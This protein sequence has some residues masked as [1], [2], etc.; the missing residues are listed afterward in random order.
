MTIETDGPT[1]IDTSICIHIDDIAPQ[2]FALLGGPEAP[3]RPLRAY[4]DGAIRS[5]YLT[6]K[7]GWRAGGGTAEATVQ[8]FVRAGQM[9]AD[10]QALA[11]LYAGLEE[12]ARVIDSAAGGLGGCP[13]APGATGNVA[14]EDVVYM[15]EGMGI[16]TGV[17]MKRLVAAANQIS[18]LIGKPP[19]SRVASAINA[20]QRKAS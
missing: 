5:G 17:D 9:T 10:G 15:L 16:S 3:I 12:G 2:S 8:L 19:V 6:I 18:T 13:Y 20:A 14:T 7:A 1:A 4:P 11:N